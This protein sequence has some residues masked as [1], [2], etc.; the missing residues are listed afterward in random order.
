MEADGVE[1]FV[2]LE[3]CVITVSGTMDGSAVSVSVVLKFS[4]AFAFALVL[5]PLTPDNIVLTTSS[6]MGV[7]LLVP[8]LS[9]PL[10][11]LTNNSASALF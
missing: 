11:A 1:N 7:R 5:V 9:L 3:V 10:T 8:P 2:V 6:S 4:L